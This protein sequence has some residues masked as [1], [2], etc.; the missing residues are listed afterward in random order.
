[1]FFK[2]KK[3]DEN[4]GY[5]MGNFNNAMW[6][7]NDIIQRYDNIGEKIYCID[8][9]V[10]TLKTLKNDDLRSALIFELKKK[11]FEILDY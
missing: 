4:T 1:M 3:T 7:F 2:K 9:I 11:K 6:F 8:F 5:N 10:D